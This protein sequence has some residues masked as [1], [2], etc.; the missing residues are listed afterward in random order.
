MYVRMKR[1][2]WYFLVVALV[3][4]ATI[5][6]YR[7]R[8]PVGKV[9]TFSINSI[10]KAKNY[11]SETVE[12]TSQKVSSIGK[13]TIKIHAINYE[14]LASEID[15]TILTEVLR[16]KY[17][18]E[19]TDEGYD[20]LL[21]GFLNRT[22][23]PTD[24][25]IVKIHYTSEAHIGDPRNHLDSHDLVMGFD[26]I[27]HPN[28]IRVPYAYMRINSKMR[29]DYNRG[30]KC[31]P[32]SKKHFACFLA[33]NG[34][35][36]LDKFDGARARNRLFHKLSLYKKVISGGKYLNNIGNPIPYEET[37]EWLSQCKFVIAYENQIN[38]PGY[39]TEKPFQ[40]WLAGSVPLYDTHKSGLEDLNSNATIYAGGF[41]TEDELIN[42]IKKVDND[43][44]LYCKIWNEQII[45]DPSKDY[46]A[47]KD[48]IRQKIDE[49][50]T[51]KSAK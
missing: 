45:T 38:Y 42:Y 15:V 40:A 10:K 31:D 46:E 51:R 25:N 27:E 29:H 26:F 6:V 2:L 37:M 22:P 50:L 17:N 24:P 32:K 11:I 48:K 18:I 35:E 13:P 41:A 7:P 49:I 47:L 36:W 5:A 19:Y 43:D 23:L 39:V 33:S 3:V 12:S 1:F 30:M 9:L 28:Y 14:Y 20:I 4:T 16:E 44:A 34:G 8:S 21:N